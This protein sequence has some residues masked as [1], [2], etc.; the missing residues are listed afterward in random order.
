MPSLNPEI[1]QSRK[2]KIFTVCAVLFLLVYWFLG[3][4]GITFSDDVYYLLAGKKFWEGS[5]VV[6]DYH[7]S[8]RWGA[9]I[10]SGF[11]GFLFG[12]DPQIS[13]AISL[14]S[15]LATFVILLFAL[16]KSTPLL[17][18]CLWFCSQVYL[19][20]FLTKVYPDSQLVF[21]TFLIPFA[22]IYRFKKPVL[23]GIA[24]ILALFFGFLT[25]ETIILLAPFPLILFYVDWKE[26]AIS[27]Q[28]Y[29]TI[30]TSGF[31]LLLLY[32]GYFWIEFGDPLHRISS[33]NAGHYISEF[34]YADKGWKSILTR[35]T[36]LPITTFVERSYWPWLIFALPG[37]R[38]GLK[39]SNSNAFAFS[40]AIAC[41][42]IGFWFMTS[43]LEF[44][45]P[46]YLNPR[47]LIILIPILVFL[48]GVGWKSWQH[49]KRWKY[50]LAALVLLGVFISLISLDW[51]MAAF[52]AGFLLPIFLSNQK[53]QN[54]TLA[55]VLLL[56]ALA[57][58]PYQKNL[59]EYSHLKNTLIT[60][61]QNTGNK[62]FMLVNNIVSFSREVLFD[63]QI[64][65][66]K[67]LVGVDEFL[68]DPSI[69]QQKITQLIY[70]YYLH[71]YPTE[72]QELDLAETKLLKLGYSIETEKEEK[73]V[74]TRVW[75]KD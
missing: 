9:Y 55:G 62:D 16:P 40:L 4:D 38:F 30:V 47:H 70:L 28:F 3:F 26:K 36:I 22:A 33:I 17:I 48:I 19:M 57:A 12:Y 31:F 58:I 60:E 73:Q 53:L 24:L 6:N 25:K 50:A 46:I 66:Q 29:L 32:L 13:S 15:Y 42:L 64:E 49:S 34:T 27:T 51:K 72:Q 23:A 75:V 7:F 56:P 54:L 68:A 44:Y 45:N 35:L 69:D 39:R 52:Q 14:L 63:D 10:P 61:S 71:A 1:H 11:I 20:H 8:S 37:F 18:P 65:L 59:K 67:K 2:N 43:T 74:L 21:W 5:M 41:L